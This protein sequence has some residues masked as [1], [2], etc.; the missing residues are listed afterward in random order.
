MVSKN[1]GTRIGIQILWMVFAALLMVGCEGLPDVAD[2]VDE[3]PESP[4]LTPE[5]RSTAPVE[6]VLLDPTPTAV[7]KS[8]Q[9]ISQLLFVSNRG[10]LGTTDI[11]Q[12]NSDG[13]SL[14]RLTQDPANDRDPSWS[15]DREE[16]AF[17]S[18]RTGISQ[19][20]LLTLESMEVAQLTDHPAGAESPTW[21]PDGERIAFLAVNRDNKTILVMESSPGGEIEPV[22]VNLGGLANLAWAPK[23][24]TIAFS[25][26]VDGT[27][28]RERDVYS[29]DMN[30]N[31]LV[32]LTNF[33]GI[34]DNPAWS[35]NGERLTFQSNRAGDENI[36]V[37]QANGTLQT[38]LTDDPAVDIDPSWSSD[39]RT[40][41]FSS[42]R[43]GPF[44]IYLM[45]DSGADQRA[46]APFNADDRGPRWPPPPAPIVGELAVAAG[47]QTDRRDI[48]VISDTG[49]KRVEVLKSDNSDETMPDW[50]PD[51]KRIVLAS[52]LGGSYDIY[53][54]NADGSGE[55]IQLTDHPGADMHPAWSPDGTKI[56]F[57]AKRDEG[58][59]DVW[60]IEVDGSNQ[61]NLTANSPANDGN[62]SWSPD[63]TQIVFS[64]NRSDDFNIY[65]MNADGSGE[66]LQLTTLQGDEFHPDWSPDGGSIAFRA[67]SPSTGKH[68]VY[69]MGRDGS[70]PQPLFSSQANDDL[71]DW[72]EDGGRIAFASDRA[73]PG[74]RNLPGKFDI[75]VYDLAT[76]EILQVTQGDKDVRYPDWKPHKRPTAQ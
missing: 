34:D 24:E 42:D 23:G 56:A 68:Q 45:S 74:N 15:P 1:P 29:L 2:L 66:P 28:E 48:L 62:P 46:L 35:P 9:E 25:A 26:Q 61:R 49:G 7:A 69:V 18:D 53:I 65:V 32:N 36:Y 13:S 60:V 12:I 22:P 59:W 40:I 50:S 63:G 39:G 54:V 58:D 67:L 43:G 38:P 71:P 14:I 8:E 10:G 70:S 51:G 33:P 57:E 31:T 47:F 16:I 75:Y 37:M 21:S 3:N 41:A 6:V 17:A 5:A 64:T 20:Y 72:S 11:Y 55:P 27:G 73:N 30:E 44:D 76:G 4:D 52:N 19:I